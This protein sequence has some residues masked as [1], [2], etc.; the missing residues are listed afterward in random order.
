MILTFHGMKFA[1]ASTRWQ[2]LCDKARG[3][4]WWR[5]TKCQNYLISPSCTPT[6]NKFHHD[7]REQS[8]SI[9]KLGILVVNSKTMATDSKYSSILAHAGARV[10]TN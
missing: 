3:S 5:H 2:G 7:S 8:L 4:S 9:K 10:N 6:K 1:C